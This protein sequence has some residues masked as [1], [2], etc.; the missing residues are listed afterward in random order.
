[1]R[2]FNLNQLVI[3]LAF[4]PYSP[5]L[6][7]FTDLEPFCFIACSVLI[8]KNY[9]H[10]VLKQLDLLWIFAISVSISGSAFL[11]KTM[12]DFRILFG[13]ISFVIFFIYGYA[14][15]PKLNLHTMLKLVKFFWVFWLLGIVLQV[16][17]ISTDFMSA[18]RTTIG[19]GFTS[20]APEATFAAL[21]VISVTTLLI[22]YNSQFKNAKNKIKRYLFFC[23]HQSL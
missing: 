11:L 18:D 3:F 6:L 13:G 7:S 8:V 20:L 9:K 2:R 17:G 23:T 10:V 15:L 1:M 14:L 5:N 4:L 21:Q 22:I 12:T 16:L 19:R